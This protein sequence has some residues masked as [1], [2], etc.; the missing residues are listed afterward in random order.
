LAVIHRRVIVL[1]GGE[2]NQQEQEHSKLPRVK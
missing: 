2:G 1:R